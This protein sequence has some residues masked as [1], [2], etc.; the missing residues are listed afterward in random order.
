MFLYAVYYQ[1]KCVAK[2]V[3]D[4]VSEYS[5]PFLYDM[6]VPDPD[7]KIPVHNGDEPVYPPESEEPVPGGE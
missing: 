5:C 4:G 7:N 3:W 6:I 2:F 1:G